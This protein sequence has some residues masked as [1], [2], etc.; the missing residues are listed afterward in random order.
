MLA[1][2]NENS[3]PKFSRRLIIKSVLMLLTLSSG[4]ALILAIIVNSSGHDTSIKDFPLGHATIVGEAGHG[5]DEDLIKRG[6]DKL[7]SLSRYHF[8]LH[9]GTRWDGLKVDIE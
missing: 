3:S 5:P 8:M 6:I 2:D 9:D 4:G 1:L 7:T